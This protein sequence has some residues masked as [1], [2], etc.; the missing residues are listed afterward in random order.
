[1]KLQGVE[2]P[3]RDYHWKFETKITTNRD[4]K[5]KALLMTAQRETNS[6]SHTLTHPATVILL[7]GYG[8]TKESMSPWALVLA[9][10]GY[11]VV[12]LDLRGH[13]ESGGAR[14][15][16]GKYEATD[17]RQ[18]LDYLLAHGLCD[19]RVGV[20]GISYGATMALHWAAVDPRIRSVVAI[21]PYN[22]PEEAVVRFAEMFNLPVPKKIIRA[23]MARAATTLEFQWRDWSAEAAMRRVEQPVLLISGGQD[24]I[25]RCEDITALESAC[26]KTTDGSAKTKSII[27]PE[28]NHIMLG[29]WL[30]EELTGPVKAWWKERLEPGG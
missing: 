19:E 23:G 26:A 15:G 30:L 21:A 11:R 18:A 6:M 22:Q 7:H 24:D 14:I 3:P 9:Q 4:G 13:G 16:F 5:S 1:V 28:A 25:C 29:G 27:I 2:F 17:L 10:A 20:M 12:A 8:M